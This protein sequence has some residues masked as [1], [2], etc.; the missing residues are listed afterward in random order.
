[1]NVK[2][3]M[4][5]NFEW[6]SALAFVMVFIA[7][8]GDAVISARNM[9]TVLDNGR[10]VTHTYQVISELQSV[11]STLKEVQAAQRSYVI[12]SEKIYL[13]V[14][15]A[16]RAPLLK[17]LD[18][19]K[20]LTSDNPPQQARMA[21]LEM[22]ALAE[23]DRLQQGVN[24]YNTNPAAVD[25]AVLA[26]DSKARMGGI[27][28]TIA[29]GTNIEQDLLD[30]RQAAV[31]ISERNM[32][33]AFAATTAGSLLLLCLVYALTMRAMRER[34]QNAEAIA[35]REEWLSTTLRSIGDAVLA[36]DAEGRILFFNAVAERLTGW[37][38]REAVGTPAD[39]IFVV[40]DPENRQARGKPGR[41]H[42]AV[43]SGYSP[44]RHPHP[45]GPQH[46]RDHH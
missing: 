40:N 1:M 8:T 10:W 33:L 37:S 2:E 41:G 26:D 16:T 4:K 28:D 31:R 12:T 29:E 17:H 15:S 38:Y 36:T 35:R 11:M 5:S 23:L 19:L 3:F 6:K 9:A 34:R 18:K 13:N 25:R 45:R 24:L 46:A 22:Q 7:L 32:R 43:R 42:P 27:S 44:G 20:R 30:K 21:R 39:Q 14:Y